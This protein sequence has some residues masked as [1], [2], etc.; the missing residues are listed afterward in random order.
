PPPPPVDEA[1]PMEPV[2][3]EPMPMEAAPAAPAEMPAP[4][5]APVAEEGDAAPAPQISGH[6]EAAYHVNLSEPEAEVPI[7]LRSYDGSSGNSFYFHAAHLAINHS[8]TDQ[9]SATIE[10]DAGNDAFLSSGALFDVQEAYATYMAPFGLSL[11][12]GKFATYEGI[13]LIEGPPN[14][15]ITR[16]F[17]FGLAEPFW[18]V[19]AKAHYAIGDVA[20]IG[21]GLV[22]GW[23]VLV[24]NNDG[25]TIIF[26]IGVTPVEQFWAGLS[27]TYGPEVADDPTAIP[28]VEGEDK[29][30]SLDLTGAAIP[31]EMITLNFQANFG[32]EENAAVN[33][34]D[35][36]WFGFGV[37]P[38]LAFDEAS[39]GA[40]FEFF[41]DGDGART[42]IE[43]LSVWNL[44]LTPGYTFDEALTFRAEYRLDSASEDVFN[45]E[46][47]QHTVALGAHYV[48]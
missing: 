25:K 7:F 16:G 37:Q 2:P 40:R 4:A 26:R 18:H 11:T 12:A 17:L 43:D 33:G 45:G 27:G 22:N 42:G 20:D 30:F 32:S 39:V 34:D 44:T 10:I 29:R 41:S 36:S 13:E 46:G 3:A 19:G 28:P 23:D 48:F 38:V 9:V 8:F 31:T 35:A 14:P 6:V 21:V 5:E 24:D 15:T 1:A 47:Q